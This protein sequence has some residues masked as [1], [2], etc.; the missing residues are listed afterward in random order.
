M[1][2]FCIV[3]KDGEQLIVHPT[4]LEAHLA[5]HW[6]LIGESDNDG[7]KPVGK[8]KWKP[9]VTSEEAPAAEEIPAKKK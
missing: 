1:P 8:S 5:A 4:T 3:E 6:K 9:E 7:A 2:K